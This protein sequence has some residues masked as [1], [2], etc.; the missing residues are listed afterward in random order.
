MKVTKLALKGFRG[1]QSLEVEPASGLTFIV[2][3]NGTGK[4]SVIDGFAAALGGFIRGSIDAKPKESMQGLIN[5]TDHLRRWDANPGEPP[6][7]ESAVAIDAKVEWGSS[8]ISWQILS[9][10]IIRDGAHA[11]DV[12]LVWNDGRKEFRERLEA[13]IK[14]GEHLPLLAALRVQRAS[15]GERTE[16]PRISADES[17][18]AE[19]LTRWVIG[20]WIDIQWYPLRNRWFELAARRRHAGT[21]AEAAYQSI[22]AAIK[23]ALELGDEPH[24]N[25]DSRDFLIK[26]P[27][28]GWRS[29]SLMSDGWRAYV[30]TV[31]SVALRCAEINPMESDAASVTPGVLLIDELEQH[32]HP[33][34]QLEIVDGLRR[35]FPLFQIIATT[36]SPLVLTDL[37]SNNADYALRLDRDHDGRI[38][39]TRLLAP[40]GRDTVQV[41]TGE[42]FGIS[43]TLD[44][45]TLRMLSEHRALLRKG[46]A[47]KNAR[48]QLEQEL[49]KRLGR[50]AETS[51]EELVLSVVAELEGDSRFEKLSHTQIVDLRQ[52]VIDKI[53]EG[54]P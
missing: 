17:V 28:E 34:L 14:N 23:R 24:F 18:P 20:P 51:V 47:A 22:V 19:R 33:A 31:V 16:L 30:S 21:R 29:V 49:R 48:E 27:A 15:L 40:V 32:L 5:E 36:H 11:N 38:R 8:S 45:Q 25:A 44:D 41:L 26:L 12:R 7:I 50:Y 10:H 46:A 1:F 42:W 6:G 43:S 54:L 13:I 35:A 52:K 37:D 39:A 2:A 53:K 9:Y 4:T 3:M